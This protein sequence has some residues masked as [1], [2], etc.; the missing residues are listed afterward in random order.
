[1]ARE[2]EAARAY[3]KRAERFD[4]LNSH[5]P[6]SNGSMLTALKK[7]NRGRMLVFVMGAFVG[8][9]GDVSRICDIIAYELARIHV[10]YHND[11]AKRTKGGIILFS[12]RLSSSGR[13]RS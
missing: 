11:D 6:G 4:E 2:E 3:L 9:S 13:S 7:Y 1:M 8:I 12:T 5:P 10:S